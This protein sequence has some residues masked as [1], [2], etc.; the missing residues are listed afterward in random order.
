MTVTNFGGIQASDTSYYSDKITLLEII[1]NLSERVDGFESRI[2]D[3]EALSSKV[4]K[5][6]DAKLESFRV[7]MYRALD[8][9]LKALR[10]YVDAGAADGVVTDPVT[11]AV[12]PI[13]KCV[14]S[15]YTAL[16]L[17]GPFAKN[18]DVDV[19]YYNAEV[20]TMF[21]NIM[22]DR[23]SDINKNIQIGGL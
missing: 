22:A 13:Q 17:V 6:V 4:I 10:D 18:L 8:E 7:E 14:D 1:R 5:E 15:L 9:G 21:T 11:G 19:S 20:M 2:R 23:N 3:A 16:N 12:M